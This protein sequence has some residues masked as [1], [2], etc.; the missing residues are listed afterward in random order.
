MRQLAPGMP[1]GFPGARLPAADQGAASGG[2]G[3]PLAPGAVGSYQ[4]M[5]PVQQFMAP[6]AAAGGG[7]AG[8]G[9]GGDRRLSSMLQR[10]GE[11]GG[12]QV[13]VAVY[14]NQLQLQ[15]LCL[16][17]PG[18]SFGVCILHH[19]IAAMKTSTATCMMHTVC[20]WFSRGTRSVI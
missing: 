20:S 12:P 18:V 11:A 3:L 14:T 4:G 2:S 9:G 16:M 6:A 19:D 8:G 7:L 17:S 13:G 5:P 15:L 1:Q 10:P